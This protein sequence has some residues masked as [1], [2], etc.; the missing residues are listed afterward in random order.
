VYNFRAIFYAAKIT[1]IILFPNRI[2]FLTSKT[3]EA[4]QYKKAPKK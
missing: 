3:L 2:V 1:G 4:L